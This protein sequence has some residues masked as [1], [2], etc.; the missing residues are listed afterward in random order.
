[1]RGP[2]T[3]VASVLL[4]SS[5]VATAGCVGPAEPDVP[6][7]PTASPSASRTPTPTAAPTASPTTA[8]PV[9]APPATEPP[10]TAA[11]APADPADPG[12]PP[13]G[14]PASAV[15]VVTFAG[16]NGSTGAVEVGAY[17]DV[18]TSGATCTLRLQGPGGR[19]AEA[20]STGSADAATTVCGLLT[21]PRSALVS[22]TWSGD[23]E[24]AS[25]E[26]SGRAPV[27]PM[28]VP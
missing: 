8:D 1:M 13:V 22:G 18:V 19:T 12:V 16:W 23:V 3:L 28:E 21:V 17:A 7:S 27:A 26:H 5:V 14:A 20:T 2:R 15:V 10:A 24:F 4:L 11:P 9:P 25:P 6:P